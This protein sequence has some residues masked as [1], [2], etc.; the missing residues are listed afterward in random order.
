MLFVYFLGCLVP[1]LV[2]FLYVYLGS[3]NALLEQ[4][5]SNERSRLERQAEIISND[6]DLAL[7]ITDKLYY[8]TDMEKIALTQYAKY[9]DMRADYREFALFSEYLDMYYRQVSGICVYLDRNTLVDNRYFKLITEAIKQK[10]WYQKTV[11]AEGNPAWSYL[12]N[13]Q[14]KNRSLRLTRLLYTKDYEYVGIISVTLDKQISEGFVMN[15]AVNTMMV[16]NESEIVHSNM[17]IDDET[18]SLIEKGTDA[19]DF[20][21]WLNI[22]GKRCLVTRAVITPRYSSDRYDLITVIPLQ[23]IV[24]G[25]NWNVLRSLI[26]FILA[27]IVTTVSIIL[28]SNWFSRRVEAFSNTMHKAAEGNFDVEDPEIVKVHDEIY[29]LNEDL[30]HMINDIQNL[31]EQNANERIQKEQL[32]SRQKDVEYKMLANQINPHFLYNTLE[33]IRMLARINKQKDI[34][35]ISVTLTKLLRNT[36]SV[37]SK[38]KTLDWEMEMIGYYITIQ[39]YRFGDRITTR[40]L[41]D[42]EKYAGVMVIPFI[43]QPFVENA[44]VHGM[45]NKEADGVITISVE[46]D[47]EDLCIIIQDNGDGMSEKQI[48]EI[49]QDYNDVAKPD[50]THIGIRNVNQRIILMYGEEYGVAFESK[51]GFG[52]KVTVRLPMEYD[53]SMS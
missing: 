39:N 19:S 28:L 22:D 24:T 23:D 26:P 7:E 25:A 20:D 8:D 32:Y 38:L 11:E 18:V 34:E 53:E 6:M 37:S 45:E 46:R 31:L 49:M 33:N 29:E 30:H 10:K 27:A 21:G 52:T 3:T 9:T 51:E 44:Y 48:E 43:I 41:Y 36:I 4:Q 5:I 2:V 47:R 42:K 35:E 12:T 50:K 1:L 13:V 14:T 16:L 17:A 40:V 15:Q